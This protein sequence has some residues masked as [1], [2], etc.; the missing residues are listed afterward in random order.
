MIVAR[1]CADLAAALADAARP[2]GVVPTMGALHEGHLTLARRARAENATVV[3]TIFVNPTQFL[4]HED[5][6]RYPRPIER[7]LALCA[8]VG[9]D[10]AFTPPVEEMYPPGFATTVLVE[11]PSRRWEGEYR[12]G[13]F[14]GVATVVTRLLNLSRADRA[15]FGEKD[16]QQLQVV[17]RLVADLALPVEIVACE[18]VRDA[19][20]L[21]LSSRNSYL[22]PEERHRAL[23]LS[24]ALFEAAALAA[25]GEREVAVIER[26]MREVAEGAGLVVDYLVIV[27]PDTLEPLATLDRPARALGAV[28]LG[29]VRLID[30]LPIVPAPG[31]RQA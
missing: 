25:A 26:R 12:P 21:A 24:R 17:R 13:H 3:V 10:I 29:A 7:D 5:F 2:I 31:L 30:N 23:A 15:Y 11:G 27:D 9:V 19:D 22:A 18:T 1:S 20:G 8:S 4:P 16:Y 28:R 6:D 14:R